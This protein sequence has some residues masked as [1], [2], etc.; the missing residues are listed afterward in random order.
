[1]LRIGFSLL[2][3]F[4]LMWVLAKALRWPWYGWPTGR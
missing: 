4:A 3:V 2:I 1:M